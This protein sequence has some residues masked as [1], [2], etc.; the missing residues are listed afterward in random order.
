LAPWNTTESVRYQRPP[1]AQR[2]G[3]AQRPESGFK[4]NVRI[5]KSTCGVSTQ[6]SHFRLRYSDFMSPSL[7]T[8]LGV[9]N[10]LASMDGLFTLPHAVTLGNTSMGAGKPN[11]EARCP[12]INAQQKNTH[13]TGMFAISR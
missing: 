6:Y 10:S 3:K 8:G 1:K 4:L 13:T 2:P 12:H 5:C 11:A 9:R 7:E